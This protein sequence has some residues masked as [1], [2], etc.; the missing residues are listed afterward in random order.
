MDGFITRESIKEYEEVLE[1]VVAQANKDYAENFTGDIFDC[2]AFCQLF[3]GI[4]GVEIYHGATKGVLVIKD[5]ND[6]VFKCPFGRLTKINCCGSEEDVN[7]SYDYCEL[8]W[9]NFIK[10]RNE[11]VDRF[12]AEV[13]YL[14][15]CVIGN[16]AL[17]FYVQEKARSFELYGSS[18]EWN[19]KTLDLASDHISNAYNL[20]DVSVDWVA[21]FIAYYDEADFHILD[22]FL[23]NY[24]INDIH[25]G[26]IGYVGE[27][28]VIFDYSGYFD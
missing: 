2:D 19:D 13:H 11:F 8:E 6:V 4:S 15:T 9:K 24:D 7:F 27:R 14:K 18:G 28:P 22:D 16:I 10:S 12:F 17:D 21:D 3:H 26:N 25:D 23:C 20:Y 1:K 5:N